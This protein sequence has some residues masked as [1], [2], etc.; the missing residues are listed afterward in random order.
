MKFV[1]LTPH[2]VNVEKN[3]GEIKEI[4]PSGTIARVSVNTHVLDV[5]DGMNITRQT[6]GEIKDLPEPKENTIF[7]VS[8]V[9]AE[10][11]MGRDD[12]MIP[13]AAIRDESGRVVGCKGFCVI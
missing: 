4:K 12:I 11:V 13:G 8:R 3:N 1:N 5:V 10:A 7:I 9:L 6:L 2:T